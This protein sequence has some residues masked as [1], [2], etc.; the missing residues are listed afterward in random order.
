MIRFFK[1]VR[2]SFRVI[3]SRF[4]YWTGLSI[5]ERKANLI[6]FALDSENYDILFKL[7]E[8]KTNNPQ[9]ENTLLS[10][11]VCLQPKIDVLSCSD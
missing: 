1:W 11:F 5:W 2:I 6:S 4:N 3:R 7:V 8:A 9:F 10:T